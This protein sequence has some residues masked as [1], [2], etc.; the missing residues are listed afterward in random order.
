MDTQ[1]TD[2]IRN[3]GPV[4]I[5]PIIPKLLNPIKTS[6]KGSGLIGANVISHEA[7][8]SRS[9]SV[10][11]MA[12]NP[13]KPVTIVE[14][15]SPVTI[16][17]KKEIHDNAEP[18]SLMPTIIPTEIKQEIGSVPVTIPRPSEFTESV[19]VTITPKY[20]GL[21]NTT[22]APKDFSN[23]EPRIN[24]KT[25][26]AELQTPETTVTVSALPVIKKPV[27]VSPTNN[28]KKLN[29]AYLIKPLQVFIE[30]P[31][32]KKRSL[33]TGIVP[34]P[35]LDPVPIQ[36]EELNP[37]TVIPNSEELTT[38]VESAIPNKSKVNL[39]N[40]PKLNAEQG[41]IHS[42]KESKLVTIV[43]STFN[44]ST[45]G[46]KEHTPER[47]S[48]STNK[49]AIVNPTLLDVSI[50]T[51]KE[52]SVPSKSP[53]CTQLVTTKPAVRLTPKTV[54]I[55]IV[56]TVIEKSPSKE[57]NARTLNSIQPLITSQSPNR[58]TTKNEVISQKDP[59]SYRCQICT[60]VV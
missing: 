39:I 35:I 44:A 49:L 2:P 48:S 47:N 38:L 31:E 32:T 46:F 41:I 24:I 8:I 42:M 22:V 15:L 45:N 21:I 28:A 34:K 23:V 17:G 1:Q 30:T 26:C 40:T 27:T 14:P 33:V 55:T 16:V 9:G 43:E 7:N 57:L 59:D 18:I 13:K 5:N 3:P 58:A 6:Q 36:L 56:P 19:T 37:V 53:N 54:P 20:K 60:K 50:P 10:T 25:N 52:G 11:I 4:T 51:Q 29:L 12:S